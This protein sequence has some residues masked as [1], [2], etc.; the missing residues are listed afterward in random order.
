V[1]ITKK[2]P[3]KLAEHIYHQ[4]QINPQYSSLE[5]VIVVAGKPERLSEWK[6]S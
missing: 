2:Q 4:E 6:S 1:Y 5:A 3:E